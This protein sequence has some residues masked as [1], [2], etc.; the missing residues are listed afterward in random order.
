MHFGGLLIVIWVTKVLV[1]SS[2]HWPQVSALRF[3]ATRNC[4][5]VKL[6]PGI[7]VDNK[8]KDR[9]QICCIRNNQYATIFLTTSGTFC[10]CYD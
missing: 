8:F 2:I 5:R 3:L 4:K 1:M 6:P 7:L 9:C 10:E